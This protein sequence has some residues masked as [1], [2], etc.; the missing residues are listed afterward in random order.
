LLFVV[1]LEGG[2]ELACYGVVAE[3][4]LDGCRGSGQAV[5]R[6]VMIEGERDI[7]IEWRQNACLEGVPF[8]TSASYKV[9]AEAQVG[10]T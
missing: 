7:W 5:F 8:V 3:Y 10:C 6:G 2:G 4:R 1:F 9:L